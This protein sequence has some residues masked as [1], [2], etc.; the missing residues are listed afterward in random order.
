M[1]ND[2]WTSDLQL[3]QTSLYRKWPGK[4]TS[5]PSPSGRGSSRDK[6]QTDSSYSTAPDTEG[7]VDGELKGVANELGSVRRLPG[8][9]SNEL[10]VRTRLL[11]AVRSRRHRSWH[12]V[13]TCIGGDA[14]RTCN[15]ENIL[16]GLDCFSVYLESK[17]ENEIVWWDICSYHIV[18][19]AL[20]LLMGQF[21]VHYSTQSKV[22]RRLSW[23]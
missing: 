18:V 15:S 6:K 17:F 2:Y 5:A 19:V 8:W 12:L 4:L 9:K 11:A 3:K 10:Q 22:A 14:S 13:N 20:E 21:L 1:L 16:K 7:A 23:N